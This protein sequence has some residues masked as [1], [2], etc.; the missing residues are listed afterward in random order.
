MARLRSPQV[1][2]FAFWGKKIF[3]EFGYHN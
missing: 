3:Y 2:G 1:G